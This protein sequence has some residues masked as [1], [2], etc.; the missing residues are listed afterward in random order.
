MKL[1]I[2]HK[3]HDVC[4]SDLHGNSVHF[5][6]LWAANPAILYF[7]SHPCSAFAK[8]A[9]K[10]IDCIAGQLEARRVTIASIVPT[11]ADKA[12]SFYREGDY[13]HTCLADPTL[14]CH[15]AYG[16]PIAAPHQAFGVSPLTAAV[17]AYRRGYRHTGFSN[18][19]ALMVP[20][21]FVVDTDG[22]V[23]SARYGSHIGDIPSQRELLSL[24]CNSSAGSSNNT[25]RPTSSHANDPTLNDGAY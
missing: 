17:K 1:A 12:C 19:I 23:I 18:P 22:T 11:S 24:A 25:R 7:H 10:R 8:Q 16:V 15:R 14:N 6:S 21:I 2:G 3:A 4:A 13:W 20:S 9:F 5:G